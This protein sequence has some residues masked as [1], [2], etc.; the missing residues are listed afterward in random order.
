MPWPS[1]AVS[2]LALL[3]HPQET[4]S[5]RTPP[6]PRQSVTQRKYKLIEIINMY[7][8][9]LDLGNCNEVQVS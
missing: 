8:W 7:L 4:H 5:Q 6:N 1:P 3:P 2:D 9:E